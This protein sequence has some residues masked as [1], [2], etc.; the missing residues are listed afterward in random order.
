MIVKWA[1]YHFLVAISNKF[2][3]LVEYIDRKSL[4]EIFM[5]FLCN[6]MSVEYL[7]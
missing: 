4:K 7:M 1:I 6:L 2:M 5:R 3:G